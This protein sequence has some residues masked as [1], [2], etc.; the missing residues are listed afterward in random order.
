MDCH[1]YEQY[2]DV[3]AVAGDDVDH[4]PACR[5][6]ALNHDDDNRLTWHWANDDDDAD[7]VVAVTD[8]D[9]DDGRRFV[10]YDDAVVS[11]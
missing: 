5:W 4:I 2:A 1:K 10:V 7:V 3:V 11:H 9:G 6:C 8:D